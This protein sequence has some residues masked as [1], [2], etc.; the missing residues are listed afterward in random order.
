MARLGAAVNVITSDGPGGRR[1]FTA[2]AVCSVTDD[3]PTLLVCL[4]RNS[5]SNAALKENRVLCVN[6]LA[7]S[8][9]HLSPIF[10]GMTE[11]DVEGR[12]S[13]ANWTTLTTGAPVLHGAVVSFDCRIVQVTEVGTHSVFFCEVEAI[14]HGPAHEGLIYFGRGYHPVRVA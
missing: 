5:D 2:S 7:A 10:A 3:P 1:G 8:Q 13:A 6:T 12:F 14:Q 4:N 9:E 11:H